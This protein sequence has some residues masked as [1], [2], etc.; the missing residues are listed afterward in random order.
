MDRDVDALAERA[1]CGTVLKPRCADGNRRARSARTWPRHP[2][3]MSSTKAR[4]GK[5]CMLPTTIGRAHAAPTSCR[6]A[7]RALTP[8]ER[9]LLEP[10]PALRRRRGAAGHQRLLGAR[11]VPSRPGRE[12][13]QPR[14]RG[15]RDR[16]LRLPADEPDRQRLDPLSRL[17]RGDGS[18]GA[19][20]SASRPATIPCSRSRC[21][22]RR[23]RSSAGCLPWRG[24]TPSAPSP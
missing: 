23:S 22:A 4:G 19:P 12:A 20:S 17:S 10:H 15:R 2:A 11:R 24:S 13:G 16:G 18:L 9:E 8:E 21:S 1:A 14:D 6:I 3:P 7:D 5:G